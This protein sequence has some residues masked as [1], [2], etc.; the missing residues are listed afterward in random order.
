[1]DDFLDRYHIPKLNQEQ[2]NCLNRPI[3]PKE[4]EVIKYLPTPKKSRADRFSAEFYHTFKEV[5]IQ[6]FLKLFHKIET[7]GALP[8]SFYEATITQIPKLQKVPTKKENFRSISLMNVDA[9]IL[10]KI[11]ANRIQEHIKTIIQHDLVGF[12][13]GMHG[14]FNIQK[15]I[16]IIH[17]INKFKEK[18]T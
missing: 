17:Y 5:L 6:I 14:W 7:E 3:S 15:S 10:N 18:L 13:L 11:L 8:T 9:K 12:I 2:V 4:T 16:N 1:V